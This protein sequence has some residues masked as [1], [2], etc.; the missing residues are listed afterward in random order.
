MNLPKIAPVSPWFILGISISTSDSEKNRIAPRLVP[1]ATPPRFLEISQCP[2]KRQPVVSRNSWNSAWI[3]GSSSAKKSLRYIYI[4]YVYIYIM[5]IYIY[6]YIIY[7]YNIYNIYNIYIYCWWSIYD[8][9]S[10]YINIFFSYLGLSDLFLLSQGLWTGNPIW[11]YCNH[12]EGS[13]G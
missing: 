4:Y 10:K 11:E 1:Q 7:V 2:I 5:Y 6:M 12:G 9:N 8:M 3:W 13:R